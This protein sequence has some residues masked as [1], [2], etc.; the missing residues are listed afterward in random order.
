MVHDKPNQFRRLVSAIYNDKDHFIVHVSAAATD[1]DK[2]SFTRIARDYPR[3][4]FLPSRMT[5]WGHWSLVETHAAAIT[6]ALQIPDWDY[7]INLSGA[8]YPLKPVD[9]I[10]QRLLEAAEEC[11]ACDADGAPTGN[12]LW[13]NYVTIQH[14]DQCPGH[15]RERFNHYW[16]LFKGK[17]RKIPLIRRKPPASIDAQWKGS[18]WSV[19]HR[20]FC[21]W[22]DR[23]PLVATANAFLRRC[24]LPEEF[25]LPWLIMSSPFRDTRSANRHLIH[26]TPGMAHPHVL[27]SKDFDE[28]IGSDAFFARKFDPNVDSTILD[29]LDEVS[30]RGL[31]EPRLQRRQSS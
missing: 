29:M 8:C 3:L 19:L 13:P 31:G 20:D 21:T 1:D 27:V 17:L 10:R 2:Q 30:K 18:N 6:R 16:Y 25:W 28:L 24:K 26:W 14:L 11:G 15:V 4:E 23:D 12:S 9:E 22:L 5:H 7:M